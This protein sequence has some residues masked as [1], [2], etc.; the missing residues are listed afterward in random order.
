MQSSSLSSS[1]QEKES[2][3]ME[4]TTL[5]FAYTEGTSR[6][7]F[8]LALAISKQLLHEADWL[9]K[10]VLILLLP[11]HCPFAYTN[12]SNSSIYLDVCEMQ[13]QGGA[14]RHSH[15]LDEWIEFYHSSLDS[16][17]DA[18]EEE[19]HLPFAGKLRDAYIIDLST[20][21]YS[22]SFS[23][24][25][26]YHELL[27][28]QMEMRVVGLNGQQPNMDMV[29]AP[30]ALFPF[31]FS[32]HGEKGQ[33][34][35]SFAATT[36][37]R[38]ALLAESLA[39][40]LFPSSGYQARLEG[41]L[42]FALVSLT[43]PDGLHAQFLKMN[44]DAITLRPIISSVSPS[45]KHVDNTHTQHHQQQ[46]HARSSSSSSSASSSTSLPP[47]RSLQD[48]LMQLVRT[49]SNLHEELHH[50]HFF[51][52]LLGRRHFLGLPE[53]APSLILILLPLVM[54][55]W[56]LVSVSSG[57]NA[58]V[59]N[60]NSTKIEQ[61][62]YTSLSSAL[63]TLFWDLLPTAL[64]VLVL[65]PV[66]ASITSARDERIDGPWA[67]V[68]QAEAL[69][70]VFWQLV[71]S[72]TYLVSALRIFSPISF[73]SSSSPSS[74]T[75]SRYTAVCCICTL[76]MLLLWVGVQHY[77]LA[78]ALAMVLV[79]LIWL[80]IACSSNSSN[81]RFILLPIALF[82]SP[83]ALFHV[84]ARFACLSSLVKD[85]IAFGAL[86]FPVACLAFTTT[87]LLACRLFAHS[88]DLM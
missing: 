23:Y 61:L 59:K 60:N 83:L 56:R 53:F 7:A 11:V 55:L 52:L 43:G 1:L 3:S 57:S 73:P 33:A 68:Q 40:H 34:D 10:R 75:A 87:S 18:G 15:V 80:I 12:K 58:D 31:R 64:F 26:S 63:G 41:L 4:V 76:L 49:S 44:V 37:S 82:T 46:F 86:A 24:A 71:L 84:L 66:F 2:V 51:Y 72:S 39:N 14:L 36:I 69:G 16:F 35:S 45:H 79:P 62:K 74:F 77:V 78:F 25:T 67:L 8:D 32:I 17:F 65:M 20:L 30:L 42:N 38:L 22:S 9:S 19:A 48:V 70:D 6:H 50:S 85:W 28:S 29:A 27:F 88:F 47:T 81:R 5:V 13:K 54:L 21:P